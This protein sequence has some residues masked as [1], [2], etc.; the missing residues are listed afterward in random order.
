MFQRIFKVAVIAALFAAVTFAAY[1]FRIWERDW[2]HIDDGWASLIGSFMGAFL[3]V[4]GALYV[5]K[6]EDRRKKKEFEDFVRI[7]LQNIVIQASY[8]EAMAREPHK[9]ASDPHAQ[10]GIVSIQMRTLTDALAVFDREIAHSK[11]G[12]YQ[13]RRSIIQLDAMLTES[14]H[15]LTMNIDPRSL[16]LWHTAAYQIGGYASGTLEQLNWLTPK[17]TADGLARKAQTVVKAWQSWNIPSPEPFPGTR[18]DADRPFNI[19]Q[20]AHA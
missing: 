3:A 9:L 12:D 13:L 19:P 5:S 15:Q 2:S 17:V 8:L 10:Y 1:H 6:V 20:H 18:P 7:A 16:E 4:V 11:D 14:R